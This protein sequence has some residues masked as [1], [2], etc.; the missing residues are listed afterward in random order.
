[1]KKTNLTDE[2]IIKIANSCLSMYQASKMCGMAYT[3]FIKKAK[4]LNCYHP[5]QSGKG[6]KKKRKTIPTEDI[7]NGKYPFY[8]SY[9]LKK[10]LIKEGYFEDKCYWN[11]KT[12]G[13]EF[14]P[15]ELH[16]INGIS[17]DHRL[18]NLTILCPNCHSLTD[19]YRF[20]KGRKNQKL[21]EKEINDICNK[22]LT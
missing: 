7:L 3:T 8:G 13:M 10:R 14:S 17:T 19:N 16:H 12:E 11:K 20:R 15:C 4:K 18:E 2:Q 6:M 21:F 9:K 22:A 1:M 5:N